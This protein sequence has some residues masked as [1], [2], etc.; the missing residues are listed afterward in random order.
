MARFSEVEDELEQRKEKMTQLL[1]QKVGVP[2]SRR[3]SDQSEACLLTARNLFR[4]WQEAPE[5]G[6]VLYEESVLYFDET[7]KW[8]ERY[9]V[10]RANYCLECHDGLEV[11]ATMTPA[12]P[13]TWLLHFPSALLLLFFIRR[14]L[15]EFLRARSCCLR[16][17]PSSPP[18]RSTWPWWT[19]ASLT[20]PVSETHTIT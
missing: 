14:S 17:A 9:L 13:V 12:Q 11:S 7:R 18:R 6:E 2:L 4:L 3:T 1:Q 8:R 5:D 16:G 15:K 10:V 20:T 19:D